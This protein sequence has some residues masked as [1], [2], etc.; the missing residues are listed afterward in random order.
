MSDCRVYV[1]AVLVL[2]A[3]VLAGCP[4]I[5]P[6]NIPFSSVVFWDSSGAKTDCYLDGLNVGVTNDKNADSGVPLQEVLTNGQVPT[7]SDKPFRAET[8]V[9]SHTAQLG[10]TD[11]ATHIADVTVPTLS[12]GMMDFI[13]NPETTPGSSCTI[14]VDH[15]ALVSSSEASRDAGKLVASLYMLDDKGNT[16]LVTAHNADGNVYTIGVTASRDW[17]SHDWPSGSL[18]YVYYDNQGVAQRVEV[19]VGKMWLVPAGW[20]GGSWF[21]VPFTLP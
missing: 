12:A 15:G 11:A 4:L 10:G 20:A 8:A 2:C 14:Y 13:Q 18:R 16:C 5:A 17:W 19:H 1:T 9:G 6:E 21:N 7:I 3:L